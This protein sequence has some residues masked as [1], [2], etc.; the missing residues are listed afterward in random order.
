[1]A[2][3][4][5]HYLGKFLVRPG[6]PAARA[7]G[8]FFRCPCSLRFLALLQRPRGAHDELAELD[9]AEI[10]RTE[11]FPG[12]ILDRALAVLDRRV[13]LADAGDAGEA[14]ALLLRAVDQIVVAG[15]AQRHVVVVDM[16]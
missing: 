2:E 6:D 16:G 5:G 8:I 13:L 12:A 11:M 7:H 15:V 14:L 3:T 4:L 1:M 9:D 10:G